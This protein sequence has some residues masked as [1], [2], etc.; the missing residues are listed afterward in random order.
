MT[1]DPRTGTPYEGSRE[2][3]WTKYGG[4]QDPVSGVV[5][6]PAGA[7][8]PPCP[9]PCA[10]CRRKGLQMQKGEAVGKPQ[11]ERPTDPDDQGDREWFPGTLRDNVLDVHWMRMNPVEA[12]CGMDIPQDTGR[13]EV[14]RWQRLVNCLGCLAATD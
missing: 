6:I 9:Y 11:I 2:G 7:D 13:R 8:L 1:A 14:Y 5:Y 4:A 12:R 3:W 10:H